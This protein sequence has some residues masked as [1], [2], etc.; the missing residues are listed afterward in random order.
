[1]LSI[2][3]PRLLELF[4]LS[5]SPGDY[6]T[7]VDGTSSG[8]TSPRASIRVQ[9]QPIS[10]LK[11][12]CDSVIFF[13]QLHQSLLSSKISPSF[14][15]MFYGGEPAVAFSIVSHFTKH[16]PIISKHLEQIFEVF[17]FYV[18]ATRTQ[19]LGPHHMMVCFPS[20]AGLHCSPSPLPSLAP[21]RAMQTMAAT[22]SGNGSY[23]EL[24][25]QHF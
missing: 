10:V 1:V 11:S 22:A 14:P 19:V 20:P 23:C 25:Q 7:S 3:S 2:S 12:T 18:F 9:R 4:I 8:S 24:A 6:P 15:A 21:I 16:F 13:I 5:A 17:D